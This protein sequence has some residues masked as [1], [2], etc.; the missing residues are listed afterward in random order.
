[1]IGRTTRNGKNKKGPKS[2]ILD[3]IVGRSYLVSMENHKLWKIYADL[4]F[5]DKFA[6]K[7]S[8]SNFWNDW[9]FDKKKLNNWC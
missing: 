4:S 8:N 5:L 7:F 9:S 3:T 6:R 1:M 2:V